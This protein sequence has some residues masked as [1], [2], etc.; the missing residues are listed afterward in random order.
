MTRTET[1]GA[2]MMTVPGGYGGPPVE[3]IGDTLAQVLTSRRVWNSRGE[4]EEARGAISGASCAK[5]QE[6]IGMADA[7]R[8][9]EVGCATGVSTLAILSK[10]EQLGG[11]RTHRAIDPN[12]TGYGPDGFRGVGAEMVRRAGLQDRFSLIEKPS[13]LGLPALL[14]DG[15]RF[16]FIFLDGWH[17][18]DFTFVDYYYADLLLRDGGILVFD[19]VGMPAIRHVC[20]FLETHKPYDFMG[21]TATLSTLHPWHKIKQR[22]DPAVHVWGSIQAYRK[23]S[24]SMVP[25]EFFEAPFYPH[26]RLYRWWMRLRGLQIRRPF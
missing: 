9:L 20:W 1:S 13:H 24:S 16:D 23:R 14:A 21:G 22:R 11:D 18:F 4:E 19:D 6:L 17:S 25:S 8:T 7:R 2:A 12:Q 15:K 3:I 26:Y 5:I 10:L